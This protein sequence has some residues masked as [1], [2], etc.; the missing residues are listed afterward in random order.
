[1]SLFRVPSLIQS[2]F[3]GRQWKGKDKDCVYLTFDDGPDDTTT[4][5]V[6][7]LLQKENIQAAFFCLG[8]QIERHPA[9]FKKIIEQGH[10]IG[11]HTYN[12]EK[13][14]KTKST[15]YIS[16]ITKTDVLMNSE[17]FRPPYGRITRKQKGEITGL[18]KRIIMWTWN[19]HDYNQKIGIETIIK[20]A[21]LIKGGDILLFHN[22]AK[23]MKNMMGSL[24]EVIRII[25]DKRLTFKPISI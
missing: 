12:H 20:K 25:R 6:L 11:N 16:S 3:W 4:P 14:N 15:D 24:P 1:M 18:G 23:S 7:E 8:N 21:K 9:I 2:L 5:W 13:G 19:S 22:N 10:S 17:L